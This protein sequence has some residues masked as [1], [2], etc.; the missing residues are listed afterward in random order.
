MPYAKIDSKRVKN[1]N[2]KSE[3]IFLEKYICIH[4]SDISLSSIFVNLTPKTKQTKINTV[5]N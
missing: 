4:L 3:I 5:S 1:L 2:V